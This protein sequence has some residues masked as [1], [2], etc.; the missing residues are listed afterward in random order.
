MQTRFE[1]HS[2]LSGGGESVDVP[3]AACVQMMDCE[4]KDVTE[5]HETSTEEFFETMRAQ[6][7]LTLLKLYP[8]GSA[9]DE[10]VA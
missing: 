10:V 4:D 7:S 5:H 2:Q 9:K 3:G 8:L 6:G 1:R